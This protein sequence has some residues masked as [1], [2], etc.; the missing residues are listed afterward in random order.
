MRSEAMP[1]TTLDAKVHDFLAQKRLAVAGVS[2]DDNRHPTGNLIYRRLKSTGHEVFAVN[3]HMQ[4]FD[5][6][7]CYPDVRSIP[8]GVDG[9]VIVTR[10][11]VTDRIVHDC[12][13]AGVR[14][15]WM[16]QSIGNASSVSPDAVEYCTQRDITVI[17]GA[18]PMMYG[19]GVDFGHTCMRWF[20]KFS[21]GLPA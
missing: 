17:A 1:T 4:T 18:C 8:G 14:R 15:V 10:P 13:D 20:L 11:E 3:P 16:H 7:R 21:G 6:D 9:V 19:P 12:G 5:G 2:R